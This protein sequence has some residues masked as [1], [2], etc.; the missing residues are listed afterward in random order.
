M[1]PAVAALPATPPIPAA[2][3]A[4]RARAYGRRVA[5]PPAVLTLVAKRGAVGAA[6][7]RVGVVDSCG[8]RGDRR[9]R[10]R[11]PEGSTELAPSSVAGCGAIASVAF[12]E[13]AAPDHSDRRAA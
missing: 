11:R 8:V 1:A 5:K 2:S 12:E 4:H 13:T 6:S 9:T 10:A 7:V 3:D